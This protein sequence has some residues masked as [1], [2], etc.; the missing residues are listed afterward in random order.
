MQAFN[1][2][3]VTPRVDGQ[4]VK[5]AFTEGQDVHTNDL[6]AQ[7]DPGP[8]QAAL[9][10]AKGKKAQD[11]AQLENAKVDLVRDQQLTNIV[12]QQALATQQALVRQLQA[13]VKADDAGI[14]SAQV[15]LDYT[16]ISATLD[17]RC[18]VRMV[19][20]GNIV[21]ASDTNGLVVITQ[22]RP[23]FVVFTL[24]EQS[25]QTVNREFTKGSVTV[26]ATGRDNATVLDQGKLTVIDN[27]IDTTTGTVKLKAT[28]PN[29]DL[30]LWPG[31]FVNPR[32]LVDETN[33]LVVP[34]KTSFNAGRTA[35]TSSRSRAR[36]P[37]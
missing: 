8:Y 14:S 1:T 19:D 16:T 29:K 22:L 28:F 25:V 20:Q 6:L 31:Q 7:I 35:S 13:A 24:P 26:L 9:E 32:V 23:I 27:Q 10:Q 37:T 5:V 17:G 3:T 4:L 21:H 11:E 2:V 18:G 34:A 15:Q 12:T 36:E 33:G 30:R